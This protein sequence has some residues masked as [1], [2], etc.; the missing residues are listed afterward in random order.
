[1]SYYY[2]NF[3][4]KLNKISDFYKKRNIIHEEYSINENSGRPYAKT[5]NPKKYMPNIKAIRHLFKYLIILNFICPILSLYN[6]SLKTI[7]LNESVSYRI[8]NTRFIGKPI[9]IYF[10]N[11]EEGYFD[12]RY[13]NDY[14]VI[15]VNISRSINITLVWNESIGEVEEIPT[16]EI[17]YKDEDT[18]YNTYYPLTERNSIFTNDAIQTD[19]NNKFIDEHLTDEKL[20]ENTYISQ[21]TNKAKIIID[22]NTDLPYSRKIEDQ[23]FTDIT[24]DNIELNDKYSTIIN[25]DALYETSSMDSINTLMYDSSTTDYIEPKKINLNA[26]NMFMNCGAINTIDFVNFDTTRIFNM[27]HMF[28]SCTSLS[29]ISNFNP[30]NVLDVSYLFRNCI[31]LSEIINSFDSINNVVTNM[32]YMFS[33]CRI[34]QSIDLS[35]F[36]TQNV[37]KMNRM[38]SNCEGLVSIELGNKFDIISVTNME[39]MFFNCKSLQNLIFRHMTTTTVK[40]MRYMFYNCISLNSLTIRFSATNLKYLEYMFYNCSSL[41]NLDLQFFS[42]N[43]VQNMEYMF[44]GCSGL[45]TLGIKNFNTSKVQ[46][47]QY[48]FYGC[49]KL[50][51]LKIEDFDC[52]KVVNMK[53]MFSDCTSLT[54]LDLGNFRT[55]KVKHLEFMFNNCTNLTEVN[56]SKF[57]TQFTEN[58]EYMFYNCKTLNEINLL[59]FDTSKV[60]NMQYMF[61]NCISLVN[62][63][64]TSFYTSEVTNMKYMF[65]ECSRLGKLDINIFDTSKVTNMEYMFNDCQNLCEII[66]EF[67]TSNVINMN[68]M[69]SNC[70]K[71]KTINFIKLINWYFLIF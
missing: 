39:Y 57:N 21:T 59:S 24:H 56:L 29:S 45:E 2:F 13:E 22:S 65:N 43:N 70:W 28:D 41:S 3:F 4:P 11:I 35:F 66:A 58:M 51:S 6:I 48:M 27:Q 47:M 36:Y 25:N 67:N 32:E 20:K 37:I 46:N 17:Y 1:M 23:I 42:T 69:F 19:I 33:N 10:D 52:S 15:Q 61:S 44:H 30:E 7:V 8:L 71:L 64:I 34:L 55:Y 63:D 9:E 5:I 54:S 60:T 62:L 49:Y 12:R 18:T 31:S 68:S 38:F 16:S 53:K 14:L 26:R 50:K 40:N